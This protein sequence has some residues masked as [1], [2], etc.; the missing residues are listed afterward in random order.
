MNHPKMLVP[1]LLG[2]A[3]SIVAFTGVHLAGAVNTTTVSSAINLKR[4]RV[5]Y[6][7]VAALPNSVDPAGSCGGLAKRIVVATIDAAGEVNSIVTKTRNSFNG[8]GVSQIGI[9]AVR[10]EQSGVQISNG[11]I[12]VPNTDLKDTSRIE[13]RIPTSGEYVF[14]DEADPWDVVAYVCGRDDSGTPVDISGLDHGNVD[15][16]ISLTK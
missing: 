8:P 14:Y 13:N 10:A 15:F 7:E 5:N 11:D 4:M 3:A 6:T 9:V 16:Y 1:S 2:L 12:A